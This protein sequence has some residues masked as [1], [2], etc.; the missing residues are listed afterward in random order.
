MSSSCSSHRRDAAAAAH[1]SALHCSSCAGR[2]T[3]FKMQYIFQ[4][5][6]V[7]RKLKVSLLFVWSRV[8]ALWPAILHT[9]EFDVLS[10]TEC[11]FCRCTRF[12]MNWIT[13]KLIVMRKLG[14]F[15]PTARIFPC[16]PMKFL[17]RDSNPGFFSQ[18]LCCRTEAAIVPEGALCFGIIELTRKYW[19][20]ESKE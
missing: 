1:S 15:C 18:K 4:K 11:L 16:Q 8:W 17:H 6:M 2:C 3:M 5:L 14:I 9:I 7:V 10:Q 13:Q 12:K 20:W 19:S